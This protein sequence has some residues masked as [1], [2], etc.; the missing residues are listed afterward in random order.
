MARHSETSRFMKPSPVLSSPSRLDLRTLTASSKKLSGAAEEIWHALS[1]C[2]KWAFTIVHQPDQVWVNWNHQLV[3]LTPLSSSFF[4]SLE[5]E[6]WLQL[7]EKR[8]SFQ[9]WNNIINTNDN[10]ET[11]ETGTTRVLVQIKLSKEVKQR[12]ENVVCP[13]KMWMFRSVWV[14]ASRWL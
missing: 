2:Q 11:G 9:T 5:K 13:A 3:R 12:E 1:F 7:T 8:S 6:M 4:N 10:P 14:C